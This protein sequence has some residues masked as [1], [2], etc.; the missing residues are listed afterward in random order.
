MS[1]LRDHVGVSAPGDGLGAD[2]IET[3]ASRI[4]RLLTH[5]CYSDPVSPV[6]A[7]L[8]VRAVPFLTGGR[9]DSQDP[10]DRKISMADRG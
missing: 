9:A 6:H 4:D 10:M 1:S 7:T 2:D 3:P 8:G 5:S